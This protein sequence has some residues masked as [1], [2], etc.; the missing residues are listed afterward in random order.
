ME[1]YEY[2]KIKA[3]Y[4]PEETIKKYNLEGKINKGYVYIEIRKRMYG[5]PQARQIANE[6]LKER[7]KAKRYYE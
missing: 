4:L 6:L 1:R 3:E 2:P 7:I 5:L